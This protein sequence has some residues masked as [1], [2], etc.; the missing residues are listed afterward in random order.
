MAARIMAFPKT[1]GESMGQIYVDQRTKSDAGHKI[2]FLYKTH[3]V[4]KGKLYKQPVYTPVDPE[5]EFARLSL[6][7]L[8]RLLL[9]HSNPFLV[10]RNSTYQYASS[11]MLGR[12]KLKKAVLSDFCKVVK[13]LSSSFVGIIKGKP[14]SGKS[15]FA[16]EVALEIQ[17]RDLNRAYH[18]WFRGKHMRVYASQLNPISEKQCFNSWRIVL[19]AMLHDLA[20]ELS[21]GPGELLQKLVAE[22]EASLC[23][24]LFLVEEL[25]AAKLPKGYSKKDQY[26]P[27]YDPGSFAKKQTF[28]EELIDSV[29]TLIVEF[30][31]FYLD[32]DISMEMSGR[33][34]ENCKPPVVIF[35]DDSQR[36]D[37][38]SWKL[39]DELQD[40][41]NRL[42][43]YV[44]ARQD[45]EGRIAFASEEV[46]ALHE[47]M[48]RNKAI[49][50]QY[51]I[52]ELFPLEFEE[53]VKTSHAMHKEGIEIEIQDMIQLKGGKHTEEELKAN[54]RQEFL[55]FD[56]AAIEA[57]ILTAVASKTE[58][59]VLLSLQL[60]W[61]LLK[62]Q[63]LVC[64]DK[65]VRPT[66]TF[67]WLRKLDDWTLVETPSLATQ[68]NSMEIDRTLR[69]TSE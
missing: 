30:F 29:I 50:A 55:D 65:V 4:F 41:V 31:K 67:A 42:V 26:H 13:K 17:G 35:L 15:L 7:S 64:K 61:S 52:D 11:K 37:L 56:I 9:V 21:A 58:G 33:N 23:D 19:R 24:K 2:K 12:T 10:D 8:E 28:P 57:S 53:L 1:Q 68:V 22:S 40:C 46:K 54:L 34:S 44:V 20:E 59:N 69:A 6:V 32:E 45:F 43:V 18:N 62:G 39:L 14:G 25:F 60:M 48:E 49:C 47:S 5:E 16:R 27:K 63:S 51:E 3:A 66:E 36:M 38:D